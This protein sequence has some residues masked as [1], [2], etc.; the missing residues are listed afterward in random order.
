MRLVACFIL[1]LLCEPA[2]AETLAITDARLADSPSG[3]DTVTIVVRDGI[4]ISVSA[5]EPAP[6]DARIIDAEGHPVTPGL[7]AAATQIG[8]VGLGDASDTDDRA[9]SSGPL[10]AA[11][12]ASRAIDPN[13]LTIQQARANGLSRAMVFPSTGNGVFAGTAALLHLEPGDTV[14]ERPRAAM[15]AAGGNAAISAGGSRAAIWTLI[16]NALDEARATHNEGNDP[17][18]DLLNP[19]DLA[20]LRPV[21]AGNVPLAIHADREADIRQAAAIAA[22]YRIRVVIVGGAEAWRTT[23]LLVAQSIPVILD[24]LDEL[25]MNYSVVGARRDNAALLAKAGVQIAFMVSGQGIYL[26]YDVGPALREGAGIA[27]ANGLSRSDALRAIT[28][29]P[30]KIWSSEGSLGITPG[31]PADLVIWSGDPLEPSSAP[32]HVIIAGHEISR[33]TRQTLL[34][35]RYHPEHRDDPLPAGYR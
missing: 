32:L 13:E 1:T 18:D 33:E 19:L 17:R 30:A 14:V 7:F 26:S 2:C 29:T 10:G 24:P 16:R 21:I 3:V 22:E 34:R 25:P 15:F 9:V 27:V 6:P 23:P 5:G 12:D 28:V 11:F 20:S 31:S 35:D 8:L 4:I